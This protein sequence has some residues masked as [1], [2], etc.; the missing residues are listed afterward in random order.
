MEAVK[1]GRLSAVVVIAG[2]CNLL[3]IARES[4]FTDGG[5]RLWCGEE[6]INKALGAQMSDLYLA[7]SKLDPY[8]TAPLIAHLPL[9]QVHAGSDTWVPKATGEQLYERL[10]NPERLVMSGDH[11][12]LFYLLPG[13]AKWIADWVERSV[14]A[15][16][17]PRSSPPTSTTRAEV[18]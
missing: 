1:P 16:T 17:V 8:H 13:R 18:R 10:N 11:D 6:P 9:L 7:A 15:G 12:V 5:V 14:G 2:G 3:R 4:S